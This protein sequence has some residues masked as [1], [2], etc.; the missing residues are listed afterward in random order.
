[1]GYLDFTAA[2]IVF[3]SMMYLFGNYLGYFKV[4]FHDPDDLSCE[5]R[6]TIAYFWETGEITY[7]HRRTKYI[8]SHPKL[9]AV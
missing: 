8:A 5:V 6:G 9:S 3:G 4:P 7:G 2:K 1:M